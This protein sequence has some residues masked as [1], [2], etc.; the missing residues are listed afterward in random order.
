MLTW[1]T[2]GTWLPG[3]RRGF[4]SEVRD[5]SGEKVLHN[6]PGTPCE[7]DLPPLQAYAASIMT[8]HAVLLDLPKAEVL[9]GQLRETAGHRGWRLLALAVMAN[10]IHLV[11]GVPGDPDPEKL[12]ADFKAW[13]TRR[14]NEGWGRRE[15]WWT[16]SGS[17]RPKKTA[18]ALRS[19][20]EYVRD[21]P[22]PLV[23]WLDPEALA[24][25][26]AASGAAS[27][28]R[29]DDDRAT[30]A[31]GAAS[32]RRSDDDTATPASGAASARR[33][34]DDRAAPASGAASARRSDDDRATPASGAASARRSDDDR[35]AP[36]G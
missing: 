16:Q 24:W 13:C 32:A 3:D 15:H 2:Y 17:R 8:E 36:A 20:L 22:C 18:A 12:L 6:V 28:R 29:S 25:I 9:A 10:H 33:S 7:A 11:V 30:P 1:T 19:A 34:D 26:K 27:A 14:L 31:S 5:E 35:A 23:V 21:Q 4:V